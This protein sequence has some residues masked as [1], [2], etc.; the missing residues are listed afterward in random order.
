MRCAKCGQH[1]KGYDHFERYCGKCFIKKLPEVDFK[2]W[3]QHFY[4][5]LKLK[6]K[7]STK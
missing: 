2:E 4:D 6:R 3:K 1:I 5:S 7:W